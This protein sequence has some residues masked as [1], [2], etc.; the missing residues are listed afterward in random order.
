MMVTVCHIQNVLLGLVALVYLSALFPSN[1]CSMLVGVY[2]IPDMILVRIQSHY[3]VK[4]IQCPLWI[5]LNKFI[6]HSLI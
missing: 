1:L 6:T 2:F 3:I 5:Q 4:Q